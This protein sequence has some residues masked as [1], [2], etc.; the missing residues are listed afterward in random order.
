M[1]RQAWVHIYDFY[2]YYVYSLN[3]HWPWQVLCLLILMLQALSLWT[4]IHLNDLH[5][6]YVYSNNLQCTLTLRGTP[7]LILLTAG[8]TRSYVPS[9]WPW[10]IHNLHWPWQILCLWFLVTAANTARLEEVMSWG[11]WWH[12]CIICHVIWCLLCLNGIY[13]TYLKY[14][15]QSFPLNFKILYFHKLQIWSICLINSSNKNRILINF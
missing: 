10:H 12:Q 8:N 14:L 7:S 3:L 6:Y 9:W 13:I 15:W 5:K 4:W 1:S 2:I 11:T